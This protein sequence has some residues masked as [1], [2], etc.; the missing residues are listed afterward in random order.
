MA[1]KKKASKKYEPKLTVKEG[2][3]FLDVINALVKG[4]KKPDEPKK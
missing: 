4:K 3:T 2:T 1:V